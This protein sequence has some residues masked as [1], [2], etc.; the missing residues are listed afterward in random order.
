MDKHSPISGMISGILLVMV[1]IPVVSLITP[2]GLPEQIIIGYSA[3]LFGLLLWSFLRN[4]ATAEDYDRVLKQAVSMTELFHYQEAR[5]T[6][7]RLLG[8]VGDR[9]KYAK[10]RARA[11]NNLGLTSMP[12]TPFCD[13]D[14]AVKCFNEALSLD[15][16]LL[17][18]QINACVAHIHRD[19]ETAKRKGFDK[20]RVL[21]QQHENSTDL[22]VLGA[23]LWA[24]YMEDGAAAARSFFESWNQDQKT[25]AESCVL[26]LKLRAQLLSDLQEFDEALR[27]LDR[28]F[29]M[30]TDA[31]ELL[32]L[33]ARILLTQ[34]VD[35]DVTDLADDFVPK[36]NTSKRVLEAL[37]IQ[38]K[39]AD[40]AY[41]QRKEN[42]IPEIKLGLLNSLV[43]LREFVQARK[44]LGTFSISSLPDAAQFHYK[45]TAATIYVNL[46]EYERGLVLLREDPS[47]LKADVQAKT[48]LSQKFLR[49]G[50]VEQAKSILEDIERSGEVEEDIAFWVDVSIADVLLSRKDEAVMACKKAAL[51]CNKTS[52][53]KETTAKVLRHQAAVLARYTLA[54]GRD[55]GGRLFSAL[56]QLQDRLPSENILTPVKV[57]DQD[58][59]P[60]PEIK[61]FLSKSRKSYDHIKTTF[62][63]APIFTYMLQDVL[64]KP[65]AEI[66]CCR[67]DPEFT[68]E[69]S[70][71][72]MLSDQRMVADFETATGFV[73]DYMSLLDLASANQLSIIGRITYPCKVH[74]SLFD[75]VQSELMNREIPD[76]RRT[77]DFLRSNG[78]V[79][80]IFAE[81]EPSFSF[82]RLG[83]FVEDWLIQTI[84]Y[85]KSTGYTLVTDDFRL[86]RLA[87]QEGIK[88]VNIL[89]FVHD[90]F[91]KGELDKIMYSNIIGALASRFY[92]FISYDAEDLL[93]IVFED[94]CKVTPRSYHLVSQVLLPG[95]DIASFAR[96]YA[97]FSKRFWASGNLPED[98]V[99]WLKFLTRTAIRVSEEEHSRQ[100]ARD[101]GPMAEAVGQMWGNAIRVGSRDELVL[102]TSAVNVA[103]DKDDLQETRASLI[104]DI[105]RRID[106]LD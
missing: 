12:G 59:R 96:V 105:E 51:L 72:T 66:I 78:A 2:L 97:E 33:Q 52:V 55:S 13:L 58:Q 36:L 19:D 29:M 6:L 95:L 65:F 32:A 35:E 87:R 31:V 89:P 80:H 60:T 49:R 92:I 47:Y 24:R 28:A 76:L 53:S 14:E 4:P 39:A 3:F 48:Y 93:H 73:F 91:A 16:E 41:K 102:L 77:W 11:L 86:I 43:L 106:E 46:R 21:W 100:S 104:R 57:L 20:L 70:P 99:E 26:I 75:K 62:R 101:T 74:A 44:E 23:T 103:F 25:A 82:G 54:S 85:C 79:Q 17:Q 45:V 38:R 90:Q 56:R 83:D 18:P 61:A 88:A 8:E 5:D 98:K 15:K 1:S 27:L 94:E 67:D 9:R 68:I 69:F 64:N 7:N 37:S 81:V 40:C 22:N 34:A 71:P 84:M 50:G 30:A 10:I 63:Q 42:L